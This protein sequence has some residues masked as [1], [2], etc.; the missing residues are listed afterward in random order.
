MEELM[1]LLQRIEQ[2]RTE[3]E[4]LSNRAGDAVSGEGPDL[5]VR[6]ALG[7]VITQLIQINAEQQLQTN[8]LL[9]L[10]S[11]IHER[12]KSIDERGIQRN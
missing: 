6:I 7:G 11:S 1:E 9:A 4:Q 8:N 12:V 5:H 10:L 3:V 2:E